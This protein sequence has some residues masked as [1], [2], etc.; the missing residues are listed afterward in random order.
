MDKNTVIGFILIGLIMFGFMGYQSKQYRKQL[1]AQAQIDSL[2][3]VEAARQDSIR[4]AYLREH[5]EDTVTV[6]AVAAGTAAAVY[7]DT[8][9]NAAAR[10]EA[11]FVTLENSKVEIVFTTRGGQ[12]Y[13]VRVKDYQNYDKSDL[14]LFKDGNS[15]LG[16]VVF[17][18]NAVDTRKFNFNYIAEGLRTIRSSCAF[19]SR[20][21][22]ISS[23]SSPLP[24]IPIRSTSRYPSSV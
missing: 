16:F 4:Q 17:A 8:L 24:R 22:A 3:Q 6:K 9:L 15:Q 14:Y 18:P 10:G 2:A 12:P 19:R 1:E 5:P 20:T 21:E 23:R 7:S 13:S 11:S